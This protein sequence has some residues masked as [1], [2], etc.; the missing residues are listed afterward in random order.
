MQNWRLESKGIQK[1]RSKDEQTGVA[2]K[3]RGGGKKRAI[4]ITE[5]RERDQKKKGE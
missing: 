4:E 5:K 1:Q 3:E 2:R